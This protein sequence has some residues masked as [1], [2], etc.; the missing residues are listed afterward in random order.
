M[1]YRMP[2]PSTGEWLETEAV[3]FPFFHWRSDGSWGVWP[4]CGYARRRESFH[5][6]F[7]W[8]LVTWAE[9]E[10]D[11]DTSGK[12]YSWM[13]WPLAARVERERERQRMFLPPL[14]SR[15][16]ADSS[17]TGLSPENRPD[18]LLRCPWPFFEF[19]SS[20]RRERISVFP[21]YEKVTDFGR[22]KPREA[23][24]G[25][26]RF[27]WRLVELYPEETRVFPFWKSGKGHFRFWPFY[28]TRGEGQVSESR[29]LAL[30][31][32]AW[33]D[34]VDRNW[35][36]FWTFYE[37]ARNPVC[38]EHSLFWGLIKWRTFDGQ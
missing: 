11:R 21:F 6:Y 35:A 37:C 25:V 23:E 14:F 22:G 27:G 2:R 31:P 18:T 9:Y 15:A 12:G 33:A 7:L 8:P 13:V 5:R 1:S 26:V 17:K 19:E 34:S 36:K 3:L 16:E 29:A 10:A 4:V 32:I 28:E 30:F 38:S 24:N 20:V